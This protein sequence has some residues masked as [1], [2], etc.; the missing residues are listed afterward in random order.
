MTPRWVPTVSTIAPW[1]TPTH[2]SPSPG[3]TRPMS[4]IFSLFLCLLHT[5]SLSFS[6]SLRL[7][8]Y[9]SPEL[10]FI[11]FLIF[12]APF[13]TKIYLTLYPYQIFFIFFSFSNLSLNTVRSRKVCVLQVILYYE[14]D[15]LSLS[16]Y[17]YPYLFNQFILFI[18]LPFLLY[19]HI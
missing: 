9:L 3:T 2:V 15:T 10:F 16:F 5:L 14:V 7:T 8:L 17:I 13:T 6:L 18:L 4:Y 19:S 11:S 1:S 12:F